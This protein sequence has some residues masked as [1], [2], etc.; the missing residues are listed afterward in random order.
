MTEIIKAQIKGLKTAIEELRAKEKLFIKANT[1]QEQT[2]TARKD[3]GE[4]E[5]RLEL[6]KTMRTELKD[7]RAEI[8]KGALYPLAAGITALL[9]RGEAVL[10]LDDHLFLG[11]KDGKRTVPY[12]GLSGGEKVMFDGAMANSFLQGKGERIIV[13]EAGELDGPNLDA[14]L[15]KIQDN[16]PDVQV[17]VNTC[18]RP[19]KVP[20]GWKV[21]ELK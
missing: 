7:K 21:V 3:A 16:H 4:F 17:I 20:E 19:E 6:V 11:W 9:P 10:S 8:L 12:G 1:L 2:D 14:T 15:K 18:H 13:L 5:E